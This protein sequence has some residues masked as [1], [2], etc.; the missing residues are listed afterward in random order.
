MKTAPYSASARRAVAIGIRAYAFRPLSTD[1]VL[2]TPPNPER[3]RVASLETALR[4]VREL[5][6]LLGQGGIIKELRRAE[7]CHA[8]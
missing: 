7:A 6:E 3:R 4:A 5:G 8:D 1:D 2:L